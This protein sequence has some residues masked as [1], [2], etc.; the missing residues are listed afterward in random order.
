MNVADY[1]DDGPLCRIA[2]VLVCTNMRNHVAKHFFIWKIVLHECLIDNRGADSVS[3]VVRVEIAAL[4]QWDLH[5][6]EVFRCNTAVVGKRFVSRRGRGPALD[7]EIRT[8][9]SAAE[10]HWSDE[11]S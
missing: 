4:D 3:P 8:D 6:L 9:V 7:S 11:C 2:L 1:T 10:W 5:G